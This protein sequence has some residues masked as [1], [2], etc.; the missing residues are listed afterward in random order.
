LHAKNENKCHKGKGDIHRKQPRLYLATTA[1]HPE[2]T[3]PKLEEDTRATKEGEG[4]FICE[5][6]KIKS[7]QFILLIGF[8]NILC[9]F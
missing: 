6:I 1:G 5:M 8:R 2:G 9:S 3:G 4:H 7:T